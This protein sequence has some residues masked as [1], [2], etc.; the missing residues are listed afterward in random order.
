VPPPTTAARANRISSGRSCARTSPRANTTRST[1]AFPPEPNGYLHIGHA[2]AICLNFGIAAEFGGWCN[3]R[4]D[5]TNPGKEDPEFV[6]GIKDDVRW[7]GFEWHSLRHAS[8]YFEVF[9]RSALK[10]IEDGVAYVD[11]LSAEEMREYRGTLTAGGAT[12][13]TA[14]AAWKKTSTCSAAC[15]PANSPMAARRCARRST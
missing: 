9:Y 10:L 3:L 13:P 15:A 12:R 8:D 14:S 1:R 5:D 4:L 7:L 6:E 11:D 2:K